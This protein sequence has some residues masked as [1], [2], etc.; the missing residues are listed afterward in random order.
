[1]FAASSLFSATDADGDALTYYLYDDSAAANSGHFVVNGTVVPAGAG[2][3][4]TAAQLA[5]TTFVAGSGGASD[6]LYVKAYDGYAYSNNGLYSYFHVN[7]ANSV[8]G[9][10]NHA[11]MVTIPTTV[12]SA[13]AGQ[14]FAASSLFSATDADSDALTYYLYDDGAAA[15][16]GH[17]VVNGT[18]VPA[19]AAYTV[20]ATQ[21]AQTSFV[22]GSAGTSDDLYVKA[23]DGQAYSNNGYYNYFHVNVAGSPDSAAAAVNVVNDSFVLGSGTAQNATVQQNVPDSVGHV[24]L[25]AYLAEALQAETAAQSNLPQ[26]SMGLHSAALL[27]ATEYFHF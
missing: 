3:A 25:A 10:S 27:H 13:S 9:S 14:V 5:Q 24:D 21:L 18:V 6:D 15:N 17:F 2:Y 26:E 20:T 4:V 8:I 12:I 19:G 7:V 22:A 11:P 16:S 23:Y 1:V